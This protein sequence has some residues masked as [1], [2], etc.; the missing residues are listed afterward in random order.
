MNSLFVKVSPHANGQ[1]LVDI[2]SFIVINLYKL[3]GSS[4]LKLKV[5]SC[6]DSSPNSLIVISLNNVPYEFVEKAPELTEICIWP[7]ILLQQHVV[8]G[9]CSVARQLC[10]FSD[11]KAIQDLLGFRE[12]CLAACA[13]SSVWTKF[14]EIDMPETI[15]KLLHN[16]YIQDNRFNLPEDVFKYEKHLEQPVRIH[17]IYKIA[18]D[19]QNDQTINSSIPKKDLK[20]S[21]NYAEGPQV[22]LADLILYPCFQV[23]FKYCREYLEINDQLQIHLVNAWFQ[24]LEESFSLKKITFTSLHIPN[25]SSI[26]FLIN[27]PQVDNMSLYKSD[28][29]RTPVTK[30]TKQYKIE[31]ALSLIEGIAI[32]N[33]ILPFGFDELFD[34]TAVPL[35]ANPQGGALPAKRANRKCEQLENLV[36]A[37]LK[38]VGNKKYRIA[39]FCSGSGHLG[40][41]AALFLPQCEVILVENKERSIDRA[42][43]TISKLNLKNVIL[44]QSNLDYFTG[45]IQL[46]LALHACGLATDL[47]LQMC[48]KNNADFIC[49]PCCYG[50]IKD[51]HQVSYPRSVHFQKI[52]IENEKQYFNLAHAADQT[53]KQENIKTKQGYFCMDVIDTDRKWYA[54]DCG[55]EVFL[56]KLQ[57]VS[58]TNKNNLLVGIYN[59]NISE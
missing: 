13:E 6:V 51:C 16:N 18:R 34:W 59:Q 41:L 20:V 14:C 53:H 40:I 43:Q 19:S 9:L 2:Q 45:K 38:V 4:N 27:V 33:D 10:K 23:F 54:Q 55:Y 37:T 57:P 22:T 26:D 56:G 17:N 49:C 7:V 15:N 1:F 52:F 5:Q 30:H 48:I 32:K 50:G 42:K 3:S 21:H 8:S 28:P 46:G 58:C 44:V 36:K 29:A 39:D 25:K 47:V 24:R 35:T 31:A 11:E 12:A